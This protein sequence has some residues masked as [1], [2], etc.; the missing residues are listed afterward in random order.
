MLRLFG[1]SHDGRSIAD[2][3]GLPGASPRQLAAHALARSVYWREQIDLG[4]PG[5]GGLPHPQ[6]Q[7]QPP[8]S[9]AHQRL[10]RWTYP[11]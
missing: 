4:R 7:L 5:E 11:P 6:Q 3:L 2:R 9:A 10:T 8:A 1:E